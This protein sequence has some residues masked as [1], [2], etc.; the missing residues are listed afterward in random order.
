MDCLEDKISTGIN[1]AVKALPAHSYSVQRGGVARTWTMR[2]QNVKR[3]Q[4]GVEDR[5]VMNHDKLQIVN[6]RDQTTTSTQSDDD[7]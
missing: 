5:K 3:W 4:G 2:M 1:K 7:K 6:L